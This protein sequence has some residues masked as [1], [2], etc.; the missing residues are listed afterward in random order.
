LN[1]EGEEDFF[2]ASISFYLPKEDGEG[3][4]P[5]FQGVQ[6]GISCT[7]AVDQLN[8]EYELIPC[9]WHPF[10]DLSELSL[11]MTIDE[12]VRAIEEDGIFSVKVNDNG[13][14]EIRK[15]ED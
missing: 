12:K 7:E 9:Y 3:I 13:E 11:Q 15:M 14:V 2:N 4:V 1:E 5:E 10:R 8:R 6:E